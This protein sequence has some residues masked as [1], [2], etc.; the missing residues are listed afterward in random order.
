M[1]VYM[2][3]IQPMS[4]RTGRSAVAAA[5]YRSGSRL[6]DERTGVVHDYTRK[7]G[8][9]HTEIIAAAGITPPDREQL[10]NAAEAVEKRRDARVAREYLVAL[11]HELDANQRLAL[12]RELAGEL[13]ERYGV[14]VDL[15]VHAPDPA[16]DQRNHHAHL[17]ATTRRLNH[18]GLG[19]KATIEL[20]DKKRRDMGHGRGADEVTML[21]QRWESMANAALE[22][23]DIAARIDCRS[24]ADQGVDRVPQIHVGPMGTEMQRRGSPELSDRAML[25]RQ[26]IET[27]AEIQELRERLDV[28]RAFAEWAEIAP[29]I[30]PSPALELPEAMPSLAA[31][32]ELAQARESA[33]MDSQERVEQSIADRHQLQIRGERRALERA[34]AK[35]EARE[36]EAGRVPTEVR[37]LEECERSWRADKQRRERLWERHL[38]AVERQL[39]DEVR[40]EAAWNRVEGELDRLTQSHIDVPDDAGQPQVP[41]ER[42]ETATAEASP[43]LYRA[44]RLLQLPREIREA[45]VGLATAEADFAAIGDGWLRRRARRDAMARVEAARERIVALQTEAQALRNLTI[46]VPESERAT[47]HDLAEEESA[48]GYSG[49]VSLRP[50]SPPRRGG[51]GF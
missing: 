49:P 36:W 47:R 8:V 1:A 24:L 50:I 19:E 32:A 18:D 38:A 13:V 51:P 23:A 25:N 44:S 31:D 17:L 16:G 2:F 43:E 35:L 27:N 39:M 37:V 10:W 20:S 6:A 41:R 28:E 3:S 42:H 45:E 15:A 30:P 14:A 5:A 46:T 26:I 40:A 4:R 11:P 29:A 22:R 34:Q 48:P 12:A 21:R 33:R 9:V 7:R